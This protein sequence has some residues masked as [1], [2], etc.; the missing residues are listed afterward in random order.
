MS[1]APILLAGAGGHARA[2]IDVL[3]QE[4]RFAVTGLVGLP[5]EVGSRILDCPV[6]GTDADLP[7]LLGG[8]ANALVTVGQIKNPGGADAAFRSAGESRLDATNHCVATRLCL[9]PCDSGRWH[10]RHAR[11]HHQCGRGGGAQLHHQQPG[12]GRA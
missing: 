11:R 12:S 3:E 8:H 4:G 10:N 1:K 2:C 5:H 7:A 6:L 9:A